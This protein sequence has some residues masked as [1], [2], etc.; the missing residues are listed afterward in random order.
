MRY[1]MVSAL[2][3]LMSCSEKDPQE[4]TTYVGERI[5]YSAQPSHVLAESEFYQLLDIANDY[6]ENA[7]A[8]V[9]SLQ[10]SYN[11]V[12]LEGQPGFGL[13]N[14]FGDLFD[15]LQ[16][17]KTYHD[18]KRSALLV[19][20]YCS[21]AEIELEF[22]QNVFDWLGVEFSSQQDHDLAVDMCL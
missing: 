12:P 15:G 11:L 2:V 16:C 22:K 18:D 20:P 14:W 3:F 13:L 5:Y 17:V 1:L 19:D 7:Q 8:C 10:V 9:D 6:G 21:L 4:P